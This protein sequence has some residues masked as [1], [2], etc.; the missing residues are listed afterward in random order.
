MRLKQ[1][2]KYYSFVLLLGVLFGKLIFVHNDCK[3]RE[4]DES[5]HLRLVDPWN[6]NDHHVDYDITQRINKNRRENIK[7]IDIP[8]VAVTRKG[9]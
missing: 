4:N 1:R 2:I 3:D 9:L 6:L 7:P 8:A 5:S